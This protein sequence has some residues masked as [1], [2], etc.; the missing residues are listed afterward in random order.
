MWY[1]RKSYHSRL[2]CIPVSIHENMEEFSVKITFLYMK[3][4]LHF[5]SMKIAWFYQES[6][7]FHVY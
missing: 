1:W 2:I 5:Y 3:D 6:W 4:F 7:H